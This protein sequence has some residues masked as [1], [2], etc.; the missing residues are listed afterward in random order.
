MLE[1]GRFG[2]DNTGLCIVTPEEAKRCMQ[3]GARSADPLALLVIGE[4]VQNIG[5]T[6]SLPARLSNGSPVIVKACLLQFGDV[7]IEFQ[8]QLPM[9]KVMQMESTVIEFGIHKKFVGNWQD[10]AAPLH[11]VGVHAPA[12]RGN[13]LLAV[14]SVKAW[15]NNKVVHHSQADHWHGYFRIADSLLQQVLCRSGAVGIVMN[16]KTA[17]RKHDPRFTM[18]SLPVKQLHEIA[19]KAEACPKAMG[20]V[21]IGDGFAIRCKRE[22]AASVRAQLLPDSA[23]VETAA[24]TNDQTLY[25]AKHVPQVGREA[26]SEALQKTGWDATAVRPQGM[27]RWILAAKG[28]P[29]TSHVVVNG[30]IMMV[31]RLHRPTESV[32]IT[33]VAREVRVNTTNDNGVVSTTSRF[34]EFRTQVEAQISQA[35]EAKLQIAN[36][37]IEQLSQ[38]LQDVQDKTE[39]VHS[40]LAND[41]GQVREEQAFTQKKLAEVETSVAASSQQIIAQMQSMFTKM[42]ANMEL[43]VQSLVNDPDKRQRTEPGKT[44]PFA[45]KA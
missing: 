8:L 3:V 29:N 37:K 7:K 25:V 2:Q 35:V 32:P 36:S 22:D 30:A 39:S 28:D 23:Y 11:Y 31:E 44:D 15:L 1:L 14:W 45:P 17:D 43:T 4:G 26:L 38:A 24:F 41:L 40:S 13:N 9:A 21:K 16:P 42:Q 20:I 34:A 6:F 10:T 18:V 27:N 5:S 33:M 19:A 12:L